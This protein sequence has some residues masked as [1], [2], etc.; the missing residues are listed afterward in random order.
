MREIASPLDG[1]ASPFSARRADPYAQ[2][3][4]WFLSS[5]AWDSGKIWIDNVPW[6]EWFLATGRINVVGIWLDSEAWT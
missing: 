6:E 5:G 4:A 2:F 1:F 3:G